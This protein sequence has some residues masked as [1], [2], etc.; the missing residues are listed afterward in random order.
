MKKWI[1][2]VILLAIVFAPIAA[3]LALIQPFSKTGEPKAV[4]IELGSSTA[5]IART[6]EEAQVIKSALAFRVYAKLNSIGG[7]Q[8]GYYELSPSL[9]MAEISNEL[10][11]GKLMSQDQVTITFLDGKNMRWLAKKI[12][13]ETNN[14][15]SDVFQM[16]SDS[17]YISSLISSYWFLSDK[18]ANPQIYYP[19]EGYLFP[20]TY[21]FENRDVGVAE[22]FSKLLSRMGDILEEKKAL[23]EQSGFSAHEILTLA[24]VVNMEA[25]SKADMPKVAAVFYN[26][27]KGGMSLG[28]DP[29]T[30]YAAKVDLSERDLKMSELNSENP[31]NTRG[32]NM[33]GKLPVGPICAVSEGAID[34]ALSPGETDSLFFVSDK[35]GE[36]YFTKTNAEHE[37]IIRDLK[38]QGLW[39]EY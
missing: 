17:E 26:R 34:A 4:T 6:L 13:E 19:L 35:N 23:I 14:E 8:A 2:S 15:E 16:L 30:Y 22:I 38:S 21:T 33:I 9:T 18:A 20:D 28:S 27:L 11:Q 37:K 1:V 24:S 5:Q 25:P 7:F 10:Q 3:Y 31:Y 29:T 12:S 39:F 32:P 36:L